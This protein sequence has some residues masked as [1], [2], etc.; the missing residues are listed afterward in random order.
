[1]H[2]KEDRDI[3]DK[4][5]KRNTGWFSTTQAKES[6]ASIYRS[7]RNG[8][9]VAVSCIQQGKPNFPDVKSCGPVGG[10]VKPSKKYPKPVNLSSMMKYLL[11]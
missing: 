8:Y 7:L 10:E 2:I 1:M 11:G 9:P 4:N 6:G 3:S 5:D